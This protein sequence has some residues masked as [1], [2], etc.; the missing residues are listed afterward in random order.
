VRLH[1]DD[2]PFELFA[3]VCAARIAGCC[4]AL[5]VS[6]GVHPE[7]VK[8]LERVTEFW[9]GWIEVVEETDEELAESIRAGRIGRVR[10]AAPD[11]VS[12]VVRRAASGT[13]SWIACAPV[14]REGRLE[15]LNYIR[16]QSVSADYHRYGNLGDRLLEERTEP[17]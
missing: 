1:P 14:L 11:R 6:P 2:G 15:L 10:Y 4:V 7:W 16:E 5:S 13:G 17:L 3:R 12:A 8:L 9:A